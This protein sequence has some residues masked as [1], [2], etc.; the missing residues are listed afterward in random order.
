MENCVGGKA[1][2][3]KIGTPPVSPPLVAPF[4]RP[5]QT[6]FQDHE[7]SNHL[8]PRA[9]FP[10][11]CACEASAPRFASGLRESLSD[12]RDHRT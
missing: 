12:V 5:G 8:P 6:I 9:R 2:A 3:T 11:H 1:E 10:A 7:K 4:F